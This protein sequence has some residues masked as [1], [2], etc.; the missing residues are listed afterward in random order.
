MVSAVVSLSSHAAERV[1]ECG[2]G[3]VEIFGPRRYT[4]KSD[5]N[6]QWHALYSEILG[7]SIRLRVATKVLKT[8]DKYGGEQVDRSFSQG[9]CWHGTKTLRPSPSAGLDNYLM[10][11]PLIK[12]NS[13]IGMYWRFQLLETLRARLAAYKGEPYVPSS[14]SFLNRGF[15]ATGVAPQGTPTAPPK[16]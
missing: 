5:P 6:V 3:E 4:K 9:C 1:K 12:L 13:K 8:I 15:A 16:L 11:T 2:I 7:R 14:A 10:L